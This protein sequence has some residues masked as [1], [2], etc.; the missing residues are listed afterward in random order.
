M[1]IATPPS[2][3]TIK[4][5]FGDCQM[6]HGGQNHPQLRTTGK[7]YS[8]FSHHRIILPVAKYHMIGIRWY[9]FWSILS[10]QPITVLECRSICA[11]RVDV[12]TIVLRLISIVVFG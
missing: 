3:L 6:S 2:V 8:G 7:Q 12:L 10:N 9:A 5:V 1:A 4:N 11:V